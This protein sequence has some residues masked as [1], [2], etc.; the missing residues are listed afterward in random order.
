MTAAEVRRADWSRTQD[1]EA[2][3]ALLQHYACDPMGGGKGLP[4]AL[5]AELPKQLAEFPG[6]Y[7]AIAWRG[8]EPVGLINCFAGFSTFRGRPLLNVH[9]I[10]VLRECRGQGISR[11]LL[12][13]AEDEA[14]RRGCCKLTLEVLSGNRRAQDVYTGFGFA[15]YELD[16]ECGQAL[17]ME[18]PL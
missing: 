18:K 6:S 2:L 12:Q 1:C 10:V 8:D 9:D 7:S 16:P 5:L 11:Q 3:E 14:R 15:S 4:A 13:A 17:F